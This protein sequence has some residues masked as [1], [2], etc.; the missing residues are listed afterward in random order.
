MRVEKTLAEFREY[1]ETHVFDD[2]DDFAD[3]IYFEVYDSKEFR[4]LA[5]EFKRAT[6][7]LFKFC[8]DEN[9]NCKFLGDD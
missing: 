3:A 9:I 7:A 1:C 8:R 4:K 5:L 2:T 6:S